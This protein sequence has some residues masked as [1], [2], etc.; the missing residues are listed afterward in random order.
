MVIY[1]E[2]NGNNCSVV[3]VLLL[4]HVIPQWFRLQQWYTWEWTNMRVSHF[5]MVT[6]HAGIDYCAVQQE[7][8]R[9]TNLGVFKDST[10][11]SKINSLKSYDSTQICNDSLV[12]PQNLICKLCRWEIASKIFCLENFPQCDI[13][14]SPLHEVYLGLDITCTPLESS[15]LVAGWSELTVG[16]HVTSSSWGQAHFQALHPQLVPIWNTML[17]IKAIYYSLLSSCEGIDML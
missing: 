8:L 14:V 12:E 7:I 4:G 9:T 11:P 3:K 5:A 13:S 10:G 16:S 2:S 1:F 6:S 15:L 17:W